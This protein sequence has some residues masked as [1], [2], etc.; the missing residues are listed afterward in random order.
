MYLGSDHCRH[1]CPYCPGPSRD[2]VIR[3]TATAPRGPHS[4]RSPLLTPGTVAA[5]GHSASPRKALQ[6]L[7]SPQGDR[8]ANLYPPA[9]A[10]HDAAD[11]ARP[12]AARAAPV[13]MPAWP[14][15]PTWSGPLSK[16]LCRPPQPSP[17][18]P[19]RFES[20]LLCFKS[21]S[22]QS[23]ASWPPRDP[24]SLCPPPWGS[25]GA[26]LP[27]TPHAP[28]AAGRGQAGRCA[29]PRPTA[30]LY[31]GSLETPGL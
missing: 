18:H 4:Y 31:G 6:R 27:R 29:A 1:L 20:P 10:P 26:H 24:H 8:P 28:L 25:T 11:T 19:G 2:S 21:F 13:R 22:P 12:A 14:P 7:R 17:A 3:A 5:A 15:P 30:W 16:E 9:P 23:I